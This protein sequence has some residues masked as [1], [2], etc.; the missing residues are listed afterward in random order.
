MVSVFLEEQY[1][2]LVFNYETELGVDIL[3]LLDSGARM[4]VWCQ[5]K[6]LFLQHFPSAVKTNYVTTVSGFGGQ[7]ITKREIW[8][9]PHFAIEDANGTGKYQVENLL[10]A[11]VEAKTMRQFSLILSSPILHGTEYLVHDF[12]NDKHLNIYPGVNRPAYCVPKNVFNRGEVEKMMPT[13]FTLEKDEIFI[14]GITV[15]FEEGGNSN[16]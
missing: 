1:D 8:K 10:V 4:S 13:D 6:Y 16:C 5:R 12:D 9:I 14:K 2:R 7:S 15:F 3:C 11:I